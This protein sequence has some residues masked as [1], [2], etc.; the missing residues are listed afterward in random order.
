MS[1]ELIQS[2]QKLFNTN[3]VLTGAEVIGT[4]LPNVIQDTKDDYNLVKNCLTVSGYETVAVIRGL[5]YDVKVAGSRIIDT[6][7]YR[8]TIVPVS[9]SNESIV[10]I[11]TIDVKKEYTV[12]PNPLF[13][14]N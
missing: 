14:L 11:F 12:K 7:F 4:E 8:R 13:K 1:T 2:L 10:I 3:P 9:I 6:Q 5:G